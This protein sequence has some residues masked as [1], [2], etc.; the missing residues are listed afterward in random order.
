MRIRRVVA[1]ETAHALVRALGVG[2]E[3]VHLLEVRGVDRL[4]VHRGTGHYGF[5]L[6]LG[7]PSEESLLQVHAVATASTV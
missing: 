6:R 7:V 5:P 3:R 2:L 4:Y 1:D